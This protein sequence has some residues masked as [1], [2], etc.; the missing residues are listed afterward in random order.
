MDRQII[1]SLSREF[2][3]G[4]HEIAEKLAAH[5]G[6]PLYD[7]NILTSIAKERDI[8][9]D[10]LKKYDEKPRN[11]LFSRSVQGY[12]N[13]PED[14]IAQ[15]QFD[16][17]KEKADKGESF[18]L[19]GR[20][21]DSILKDQPNLIT[22]YVLGNPDARIARII[23]RNRDLTE[24]EAK[25]LMEATDRKRRAYHNRYAQSKWG[26]SA[27]YDL[28]IK[29]DPLGVDASAEVI[30]QYIDRRPTVR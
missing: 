13:S 29:S 11:L 24:A 7:K 14:N 5:Y 18:V 6:L 30:I 21:G 8:D 17:I 10:M 4:G 9:V 23:S 12:S 28:S 22:I 20:C 1:I 2:G 25:R 26:E 15:M 16:Y 19:V 27:N 3:S